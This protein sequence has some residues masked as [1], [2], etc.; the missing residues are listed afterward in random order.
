MTDVLTSLVE[1]RENANAQLTLANEY[2]QE[3][4]RVLEKCDL[5]RINLMDLLAKSRSELEELN[6]IEEY[7][8][9]VLQTVHARQAEKRS[10]ISACEELLDELTNTYGQEAQ[11]L[12][13]QNAQRISKASNVL[14]AITQL[15]EQV[16][17][18]CAPSGDE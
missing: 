3:C 4:S 8:S 13:E 5:A 11:M 1:I 12:M 7:T 18:K 16:Y 2:G 15:E 17:D 6:E 14:E 10:Q 9:G